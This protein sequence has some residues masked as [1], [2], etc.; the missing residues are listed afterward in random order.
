MAKTT[1]EKLLDSF[2]AIAGRDLPDPGAARADAERL[3]AFLGAAASESANAVQ[4]AG[5]SA[6]SPAQSL[7]ESIIASLTANTAP[8]GGS[9]SASGGEG[10]TAASVA[11]TVLESGLGLIPLIGGLIGLFR[12]G[13]SSSPPTLTK[14]IMP[15][16]LDF[17]EADTS[18]GLSG[19]SYDQMGT[20]RTTGDGAEGLSAGAYGI[21][22]GSTS[23][24]QTVGSQW[25]M[26]H[27]ADIAAAVRNAMLNLNSINDVVNDL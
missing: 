23:P 8:A 1:E 15:P 14:Y 21:G 3:A 6:A 13:N 10:I 4:P 12:G 20:P 22:S 11:K 5:G 9:N 17:E 7:N 26:D 18:G 19:I 25:F 24:L 27:S 2:T 16:A